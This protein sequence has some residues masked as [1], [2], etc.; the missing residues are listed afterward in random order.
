MGRN[1][2]P[3][4]HPELSVVAYNPTVLKNVRQAVYF[5][6]RVCAGLPKG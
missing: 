5:A 4:E 1:K 6:P 3:S 2:K